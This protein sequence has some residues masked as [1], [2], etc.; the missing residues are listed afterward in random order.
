MKKIIAKSLYVSAVFLFTCQAQAAITWGEPIAIGTA[1]RA[2][3]IN[4]IR[5]A[6]ETIQNSIDAGTVGAWSNGAGGDIYYN[7]GD[8]GIGVT[9]PIKKLDVVGNIN[10]SGDLMANG[11][12]IYGDGKTLFSI[13]MVGCV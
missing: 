2:T 1:I 12:Y 8:V 6:I 7:S 11:T 3:Q 4:E 13:M 9:N 10:A 5:T